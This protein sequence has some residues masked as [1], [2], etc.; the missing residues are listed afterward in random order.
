METK[1]IGSIA[2]YKKNKEVL[3]FSEGKLENK[4]FQY[5]NI[6]GGHSANKFC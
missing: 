5:K 6:R 3:A 2:I 4:R 1:Q